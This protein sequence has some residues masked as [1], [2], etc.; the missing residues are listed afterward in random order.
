[1]TCY[2]AR[3][4][5]QSSRP[6]AYKVGRDPLESSDKL[7][8]GTNEPMEVAEISACASAPARAIELTLGVEACDPCLRIPHRVAVQARKG[9]SLSAVHRRCSLSCGKIGIRRRVSCICCS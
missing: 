5:R 8:E 9:R 2:A 1:M 7:T 6:R 4:H 3:V